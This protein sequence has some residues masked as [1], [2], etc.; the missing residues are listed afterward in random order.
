MEEGKCRKCGK[1]LLHTNDIQKLDNT[2]VSAA[3]EA[4]KK[5]LGAETVVLMG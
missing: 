1:C 5:K 3:A 2:R 4:A